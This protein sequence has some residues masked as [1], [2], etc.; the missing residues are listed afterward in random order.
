MLAG[1]KTLAKGD[2]KHVVDNSR[3]LTR[4]VAARLHRKLWWQS[5]P[6]AVGG[7]T[8]DSGYQP[9]L[10]PQGASDLD[11]RLEGRPQARDDFSCLKQDIEVG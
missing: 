11:S 5:N 1:Q 3:D 7:G 6:S 9:C 8:S 4:P 2:L 10:R